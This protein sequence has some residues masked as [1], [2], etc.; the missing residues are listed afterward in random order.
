MGISFINVNI[1]YKRITSTGFSE[2]L[3]CWLF[4]KNNQLKII[5]MPK[6]HILGCHILLPFIFCQ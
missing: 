4:L 6:T 3:Q 2:L 1:P 5:F